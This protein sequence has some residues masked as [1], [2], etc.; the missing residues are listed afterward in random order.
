MAK[1]ISLGCDVAEIYRRYSNVHSGLFGAKSLRLIADALTHKEGYAYVNCERSL[2]ELLDRLAGL[3]AD[4]SELEENE[5]SS[6]AASDI[7]QALLEYTQSLQVVIVRLKGICHQLVEDERGYRGASAIGHSR[8]N[9]DKVDYDHCLQ[10][11][12]RTGTRL[13]KLFSSY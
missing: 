1:I 7:R 9:R 5:L 2:E 10:H 6:R 13:N 11:L 12:E 8:F 4:I 3:E